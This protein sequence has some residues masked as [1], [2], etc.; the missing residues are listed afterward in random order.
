MK[1]RKKLALI[2]FTSFFIVGFAR[3]AGNEFVN[4]FV[5]T[6]S[7]LL[8]VLKNPKQMGA[9]LPS[10]PFLAETITRYV[11]TSKRTGKRI[12]E[13]GAGT[14]VFTQE[15][16]KSLKKDDVLDVV[17]V[18]P[19]LCM[20]L[21]KKFWWRRNVC[22]HNISI[23]DWQPEYKYDYIVSGLPFNAFEA[24]FVKQVLGKYQ[25][26]LKEDGII[27]YFEYAII[28]SVT[29]FLMTMFLMSEKK[30]KYVAVLN[31]T[32]NFRNSFSAYKKELVLRNVPPAYAHFMKKQSFL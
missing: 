13:V 6:Q 19:E 8:S 5:D 24:C 20:I 15:I 2:L 11:K 4:Y 27:S 21:K 9:A 14:G 30:Q 22:I 1:E 18:D 31:E 29:K 28:P 17:E 32:Q 12:L 25:T 16:V 26:F 10:S 7:F 23:L 3:I